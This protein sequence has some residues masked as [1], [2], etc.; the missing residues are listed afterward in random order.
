MEIGNYQ[1]AVEFTERTLTI[2]KLKFTPVAVNPSKKELEDLKQNKGL[3][4]YVPDQEPAYIGKFALDQ[5][6]PNETTDY[7]DITIYIRSLAFPDNID[8]L[9]YRVYN[10]GRKSQ[11]GKFEV[12]NAYGNTA[13]LEKANIDSKTAPAEM[14]WYVMDGVKYLR[15]GEAPLVAFIRAL[16]NLKNVAQDTPN[17]EQLRSVFSDDD[18]KKMLK[19]DFKNIKNIIL[20]VPEAAVTLVTGIRTNDD[21]KYQDYY[22]DLPLRSYITDSNRSD[23]WIIKQIADAQANSRYAN[24]NFF[25]SS[26]IEGREYIAGMEGNSSSNDSFDF[27]DAPDTSGMNFEDADNDLPF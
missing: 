18:I 13:W 11:T 23:E 6:K 4:V 5:A 1:K 27:P 9:T 14:N 26:G 15:R 20:E 3:N 22:R 8:R 21:K 2:G 17:K 19:G 24:T 10:T 12:I 16:R 7:F 25:L